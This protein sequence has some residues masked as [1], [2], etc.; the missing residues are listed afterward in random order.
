MNPKIPL[1][2][3]LALPTAERILLVEAIWD[4][5]AQDSASVPVT[6]V[7]KRELDARRAWL[8]ANPQAGDT[9]NVVKD[10]IRERK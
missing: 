7:Q 1:D 10:R 2:D 4:S 3:I 8:D 5:V 6:D 9:W